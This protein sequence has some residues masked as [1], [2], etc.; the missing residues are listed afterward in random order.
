[1][2]L[3]NEDLPATLQAF[4]LK[5]DIEIFLA[6]QVVSSQSEIETFTSRYAGKLIKAKKV[7]AKEADSYSSPGYKKK[8]SSNSLIIIIIIL[9]L[10]AL[11]LY[12]FSTGWI[13]QKFN[14]KI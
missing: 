4:E 6:E 14:L 10:I 3:R 2:D 13:Q 1:M 9:I 5:D 8:R 11:V 12:G 7:V